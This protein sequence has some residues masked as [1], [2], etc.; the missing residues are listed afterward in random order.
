M[1]LKWG[2]PSSMWG[3]QFS[4]MAVKITF[5]IALRFWQIFDD[6]S[7]TMLGSPMKNC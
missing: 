4:G 2:S 1:L 5:T 7:I 6:V 3:T